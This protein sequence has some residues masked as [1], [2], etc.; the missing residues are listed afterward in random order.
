MPLI[1]VPGGRDEGSSANSYERMSGQPGYIVR[2]HLKK[3]IFTINLTKHTEKL[4]QAEFSFFCPMPSIQ[5]V[6]EP[7]AIPK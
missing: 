5:T 2:H 1:P 4:K 3:K 6:V 7:Q